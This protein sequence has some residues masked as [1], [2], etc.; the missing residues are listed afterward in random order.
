MS[1]KK[2][3]GE[4]II[5]GISSIAGRAL[6]FLLLTPLHT[7]KLGFAIPQEEYGLQTR[8]YSLIGLFFIFFVYRLELAYFRFGTENEQEEQT[9]FNVAGLSI[10]FSTI[11][12]G[13]GLFL[14]A[15]LWANL[16]DYPQYAHLIRL[17][18]G[19]IVV[20]ALCEI[21][22]AKLRLEQRPIRFAVIRFTGLLLNLCLN[23]FFL[24]FCPRA[25]ASEA[26]AS[27]HPFL[28]SAYFAESPLTYVFLS[29]FLANTVT[30]LLLSPT[31]LRLRL[32]QFDWA[33]WRRMLG[34]AFPLVIVGIAHILNENFDKMIMSEVLDGTKEENNIQLGIYGACYKLTM[35]MTLFTQAFR[36]GAE[37]FFFRQKTAS[38]A[39]EIYAQVAKYFAIIGA[40]AFLVVL[41][42]IDFFKEIIGTEYWSGLKIVPILLLANLF[43]GLYYNCSIWYKLI[44]ETKW[45]AYIS[46]IGA[47]I[48]LVLNFLLIPLIGYIGAAWATFACYLS[49]LLIA[50]F[51][52]QR[53]YPIPYDVGRIALYVLSAVLLYGISIW[54]RPF[55]LEK[56]LFIIGFNSLLFL[57]YLIFIG[58][59]E[60]KEL[61]TLL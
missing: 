16:L 3:A 36:Y 51:L 13:T 1:I 60:G 4:T 43:L 41:L 59:L 8:L 55:L 12:L 21:P 7:N 42:Y 35:F 52:G 17:A 44:D 29:G 2:L 40:I 47:S 18:V 6:S 32:A 15:D 30:L 37:P 22:Y 58:V 23:F 20:D 39:R 48:T 5:Y 27:I 14:F 11:F 10:V 57:I 19:I 26:W 28:Q 49:M 50:Y 61:K 9:A 54:V 56:L 45:G 24:Y 53:K 46:I 38:N 31:L 25:L 34:Y 33:Y